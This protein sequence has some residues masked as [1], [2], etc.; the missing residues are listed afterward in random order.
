MNSP[1]NSSVL[2]FQMHLH[3]EFTQVRVLGGVK[4]LLILL[5]S[6]TLC[7]SGDLTQEEITQVMNDVAP[8]NFCGRK[9]T[10]AM[11]IY[12]L[13]NM[14]TLIQRQNPVKKSCKY[15][16]GLAD[17]AICYL[18]WFFFSGFQ[19]WIWLRIF[20]PGS[21]GFRNLRW[22]DCPI[23]FT[24]QAWRKLRE[25]YSILV[26]LARPPT[27]SWNYRWVL[28]EALSQDRFDNFLSQETI[29]DRYDANS[30]GSNL[31]PWP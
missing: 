13:P 31:K 27:S 23:E 14:R 10:E 9:L 1:V 8:E 17:C 2:S 7:V 3:R 6:Y 20:W 22:W 5:I 30:C 11:R 29:L 15:S 21:N 24:L 25:W 12:C 19:F 28:Q 18:F 26:S 16:H 4:V